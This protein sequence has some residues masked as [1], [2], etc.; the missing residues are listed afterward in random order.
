MAALMRDLVVA[1]ILVY[2]LWHGIR[3]GCVLARCGLAAV[4]IAVVGAN[5]FADWTS[6]MVA[7]ALEP[8]FSAAADRVTLK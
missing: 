2:S 8:R 1:L 7:T 6:P 4:V 3:R 5:F